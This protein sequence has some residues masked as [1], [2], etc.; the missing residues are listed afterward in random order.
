MTK[1]NYDKLPNDINELYDYCNKSY[2]N[3]ELPKAPVS[4]SAKMKSIL[5]LA[6]Y[7][8]QPKDG[9]HYRIRIS[10]QI[11]DDKKLVISTL[12]HEMIHILQ[13]QE[14][15]NG[16]HSALDHNMP[17]SSIYNN[18]HGPFFYKE[19]DRLNNNYQELSVV[20]QVKNL[21]IETNP[22]NEK[23]RYGLLINFSLPNKGDIRSIY[24]SKNN[25]ENKLDPV[26]EDI[27]L[28]YGRH[29]ISKITFFSTTDIAIERTNEIT[30]AGRLRKGSAM[31]SFK[32]D[33]VDNIIGAKASKI[34][35]IVQ[36]SEAEDVKHP[37]LNVMNLSSL[38]RDRSFVG[39]FNQL[40][41]KANVFDG[42]FCPWEVIS[43][44]HPD[45]QS[46]VID[47]AYDY[48][49][50]APDKV[51]TKGHVYNSYVNNFFRSVVV[52]RVDSK[53]HDH[54]WHKLWRHMGQGRQPFEKMK[55]LIQ[56][57]MMSLAKKRGDSILEHR[58]LDYCENI[59]PPVEE[60]KEEDVILS[61]EGAES[62]SKDEFEHRVLGICKQFGIETDSQTDVKA[63]RFWHRVV[64]KKE[65]TPENSMSL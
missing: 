6:I 17:K 37:V 5:G 31:C 44:K 41:L 65:K 59:I 38:S 16:N 8:N 15:H 13:Y 12:A 43:G 56:K 40:V 24:W 11:K 9:E 46:K 63:S 54:M 28:L 10:A 36:K 32:A 30:K 33:Y 55:E 64:E 20:A 35:S 50:S 57:D 52:D 19:M 27:N 22:E 34:I 49:K 23:T 26:L 7:K 51:L 4:W 58:I 2:F 18:G 62:M 48:W 25:I 61:I 29:N 42:P 21:K 60:A 39:F 45:I 53:A 47:E 14:R 3:N 1:F